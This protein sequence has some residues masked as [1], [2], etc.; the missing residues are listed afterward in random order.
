MSKADAPS[1]ATCSSAS[2]SDSVRR[3]PSGVFRMKTGFV[4][5]TMPKAGH[6]FEVAV[7]PPS[8][9]V[10]SL[11]A[12]EFANLPQEAETE[13]RELADAKR[14]IAKLAAENR[15]LQNAAP[16]PT[17]VQLAG[18]KAAAARDRS[19]GVGAA[20]H[21]NATAGSGSSRRDSRASASCRRRLRERKDRELRTPEMNFGQ[22]A[23][24]WRQTGDRS[25]EGDAPRGSDRRARGGEN[26]P[27]ASPSGSSG[28]RAAHRRRDRV[29]GVDRR[30]GARADGRRVPRRLHDR[31]RRLQQSARRAADEGPHRIPRRSPRAHR[32]RP[33][34]RK[35]PRRRTDV[36]RS[37][38][39]ASS[40]GCRAPSRRSWASYSRRIR[41]AVENDALARAAGYEPG[42]GA[43]N[44]PRGR[45]RSLGLVEY[46]ERGKVVARPLLFLESE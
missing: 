11:L 39:S 6:R 40:R 43:F 3:S 32:Q 36:R 29:D 10:K 26:R 17:D 45:L 13:I 41:R 44:N 46:P 2:S 42:G 21:A 22:P 30:H 33:R 37:C 25:A 34:N 4:A 8:S 12:A 27:P 16:A 24:R 1:F 9:K 14:E 28:S 7:P 19:D 35:L 18:V 5:T 31:R 20:A 23:R 15:R 38:R